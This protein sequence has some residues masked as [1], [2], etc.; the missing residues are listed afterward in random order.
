MAPSSSPKDLRLK[1]IVDSIPTGSEPRITDW[2]TRNA[3]LMGY[4]DASNRSPDQMDSQM[5]TTEILDLRMHT[6]PLPTLLVPY[7]VP[8]GGTRIRES[9]RPHVALGS[10]GSYPQERRTANPMTMISS[11][12]HETVP[13]GCLGTLVYRH[14]VQT[15][16]C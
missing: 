6:T 9:A 15:V 12:F 5:D 14:F 8:R 11:T 3:Q 7:E 13:G 2:Q 1:P 4:R 10:N 16:V